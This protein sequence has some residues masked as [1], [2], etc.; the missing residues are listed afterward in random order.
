MAVETYRKAQAATRL[1]IDE[2][3]RVRLNAFA[4]L[5]SVAE[6]LKK[7]QRRYP[8]LFEELDI[9][10]QLLARWEEALAQPLALFTTPPGGP[11]AGGAT[12]AAIYG[13]FSAFG[14]AS[15]DA[16]L[17]S[18]A[19]HPPNAALAWLTD[20]SLAAGGGGMA[21]NA[22]PLDTLFVGPAPLGDSLF[23]PCQSDEIA[24]RVAEQVARMDIS[25]ADL[26]RRLSEFQI[27]YRQ[28]DDLVKCM[29]RLNQ[30]LGNLLARADLTN[31]A[32]AASVW[33]LAQAVAEMVNRPVLGKC[34]HPWD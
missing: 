29:T 23:S 25:E 19:G 9:D 33:R 11:N 4:L 32:D 17:L 13:S 20:G 21:L 7:T 14:A 5:R 6:F 8:L 22:I 10:P 30:S 31:R 3:D 24:A 27:S 12:I 18:F 26:R 1:R 28:V 34:V 2:V 16:A 15:T